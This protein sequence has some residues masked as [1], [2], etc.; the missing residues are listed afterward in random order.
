MAILDSLLSNAFSSNP[1][2]TGDML[3][4]Y[5]G[6]RGN[7]APKTT[8]IQ[9]D[10]DGGVTV[11]HEQ[12][13]DANTAQNAPE[14]TPQTP[15]A[16]QLTPSDFQAPPMPVAPA[17]APNPMQQTQQN[18][19]SA[20]TGG[21]Q[22]QPAPQAQ[23]PAAP[24]APEM[25]QAGPGVQVASN[26][27]GAGVAQAAQAAQAAQGAVQPQ[28]TP[29][30]QPQPTS[31]NVAL[32]PDAVNSTLASFGSDPNVNP[33]HTP[34]ENAIHHLVLNSPVNDGNLNAL[35]MG[36]YAGGDNIDAATK[37][38][39][40]DEFAARLD[41]KRK[42]EAAQK[43]VNEM[44]QGGG[45][46]LQR[47][48][49]DKSEEGS[50]LKAYLFHRLGLS[51][52]A[53]NE[54]QKL[55]AGD[56]WQQ[57]LVDGKPAWIKYNGQGAPVKGYT[58]DGELTGNELINSIGMKGAQTHTQAY[59]DRMTGELYNLQTTPLGPRYVGANGKVFAGDSAN[60]YAYGIGSDID[61]K[62]QIDL[63]RIRNKIAGVPMEQ[64]LKIIAEDETKNGP[65][66]PAVKK[67]LLGTAQGTSGAYGGFT[68]TQTGG[69]LPGNAAPGM[70]TPVAPGT[71]ATPQGAAPQGPVA[72]GQ[73]A[74]GPSNDNNNPGNIMSGRFAQSQPG[75]QGVAPN[76][77]AVFDT[78]EHGEAAQHN[79]LSGDRYNNMPLNQVPYTW[80][81]AGHGDNNPAA[82]TASMKRLTGFDDATM[83]KSYSQLS[84][85][86]QKRWRDAQQ[87]VEHGGAAPSTGG[88]N[89]TNPVS[90]ATANQQAPM[91]PR[92]DFATAAEYEAYKKS[93]AEEDAKLAENRAKSKEGLAD[94]QA[95][96]D[97]VLQTVGDVI[98][99]PGFSTNV[100]VPGITGI[101]QLPGTQARGW[102]AKYEQ[103]KGQEF[104]SAFNS[105]R[106]GGSISDTEGKAATSAMAALN[107]PGISEEEFKRNSQILTD[108]VKKG[109][110]RMRI[111]SGQE[112]DAKYMLGSQ[113]DDAKVQAYNWAKTHANDPKARQI[114]TSLGLQ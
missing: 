60:L 19:L 95:N 71:A 96:A 87:Q 24:V 74:G 8:T 65:M 82:Y 12:K 6:N 46:G 2:S 51:D 81:P 32:H 27:P 101:L 76:G 103:L 7:T 112:P 52:L 111:K 37:K 10:P 58:S 92:S 83:N 80:A 79:L 15:A 85:S 99:H 49:G 54:Q 9:Q 66:D 44:I 108:T 64:A 31:N 98:N 75:Y 36:A 14:M 93:K 104:L 55:G 88:M 39:Y 91:R 33:N 114:M 50:Y 4:S 73:N 18:V 16:L 110:N 26:Q 70:V 109:A 11:T 61:V 69:A 100:G 35:G 38:A 62:N 113:S 25:P 30:T 102:K 21:Q 43:K 86:E 94:Y 29:E 77:T 48:L 34:E 84:P 40:N 3:S 68:N 56:Q 47:A 72:P 5:L 89:I 22:G 17:A 53:K 106:G 28:A 107:D 20:I 45:A 23:A 57:T 90:P 78:P 13:I 1:A 67:S 42:A 63:N 105:L 97:Q 41:Q 59:K